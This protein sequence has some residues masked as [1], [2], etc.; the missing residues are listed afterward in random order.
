MIQ[1]P[2]RARDG[3]VRTY[4]LVDDE[5]AWAAELRWS[6]CRGYAKRR[7]QHRR[8]TCLLALHRCVLGLLPGDGL[9]GDHINGNKLDNRRANLRVVTHAQNMQNQRA[10]TGGTSRARGVSWDARRGRWFAKVQVAGVQHAL[11]RFHT[12]HEAAAAAALFRAKHMTH[13]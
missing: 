8:A 6:W 4:A 5:D 7:V 12:E 3:S 2:I 1:I 13:A 10:N 11:G 9:E